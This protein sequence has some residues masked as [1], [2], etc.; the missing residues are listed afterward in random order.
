MAKR[1]A[2]MPAHN[3]SKVRILGI[4]R[5]IVRPEIG[6]TLTRRWRLNGRGLRMIKA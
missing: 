2:V 6:R 1:M 3:A 5:L 4:I